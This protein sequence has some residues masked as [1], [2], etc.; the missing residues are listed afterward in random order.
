MAPEIVRRDKDSD[1][2]YQMPDTHSDRFSL[3]VILFMTLC[4][5]NPFE[6]ECLKK[7]D[8]IDETA[9]LE[10]F[11]TKPL[12][13]YHKV[14]KS[15][16]PIRGYHTSVIKRWPKL[17]IYI[18][19][20]FH[21]TFVD[22]LNDRENERTTELEWIKLLTKYRDEL[23]TCSCGKQYICGL[24]ESELKE[25]CPYCN[26]KTK[27][28]CVLQIGKHKIALEPDKKLYRFHLDKY[29]S[30]YNIPIGKVIVNK[31]NPS[32]WGIKIEIENDI[33]IKDTSEN[34]KIISSKGVI[35]IINNLKIKFDDNLIGTIKIN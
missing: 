5:G 16:R 21:R 24:E 1:G 35:P 14:D 3:A 30:E 10:M 8:I 7:Y 18:K 13:I 23:I 29:S 15:N 19:E 32:I 33:L 11:G 26:S 34:T 4:L 25:S 27:K 28:Y 9:D 6:G 17:P 22:G 12:F 20:A 31:N 2:N